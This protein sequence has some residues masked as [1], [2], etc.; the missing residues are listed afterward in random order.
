M[1]AHQIDEASCLLF[2]FLVPMSLLELV[3]FFRTLC[4]GVS[5][6][7]FV[8]CFSEPIPFFFGNGES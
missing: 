8:F 6:T 2:R 3:Y 5:A 4:N 7:S 1:H